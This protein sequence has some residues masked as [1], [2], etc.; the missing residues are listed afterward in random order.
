MLK[1]SELKVEQHGEARYRS[2]KC[3]ITNDELRWYHG[4]STLSSS[5]RQRVFLL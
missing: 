1:K 2:N 4:R 3:V 5:E